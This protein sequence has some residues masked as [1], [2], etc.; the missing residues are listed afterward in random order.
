V[1]LDSR[2]NVF[3][4]KVSDNSQACTFSSSSLRYIIN[5]ACSNIIL[6]VNRIRGLALSINSLVY[7][8][9]EFCI[10]LHATIVDYLT[11]TQI[12]QI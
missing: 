8:S 12:L 3:T 11:V 10:L 9:L 2:C 4:R 7:A 5:T 1:F 6:S